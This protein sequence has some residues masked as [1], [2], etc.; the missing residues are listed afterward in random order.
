M[1]LA[2]AVALESG[3]FGASFARGD[4]AIAA[5]MNPGPFPDRF[6]GSVQAPVTIIEYASPTCTHCAQFAIA[7]FPEV[8]LRLIE[9]GKVRY[10][11]RLIPTDPTDLAVAAMMLALSSGDNYY[12]VIE[13]LLHQQRHW[14]T[15][16][17]Q[18]LMSLAVAQLGFTPERFKACLG[19]R[20]LL[21]DIGEAQKHAEEVGVTSIP[22]FFVDGKKESGFLS[23]AEIEGL[24][25]GPK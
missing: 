8:K 20:Q 11:I 6:L 5:I 14:V 24:V 12:R 25:A 4:A 2:G 22:T 9:T 23:I 16:R 19:N 15:D 10:A 1:R 18:P 7:T 17:I 13:V 3:A 21:S